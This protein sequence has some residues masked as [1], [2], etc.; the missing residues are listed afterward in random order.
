MQ[1][2]SNES[3]SLI[4]D[5]FHRIL[6]L[7]LSIYYHFIL[8]VLRSL[9]GFFPVTS[10]FIQSSHMLLS[11]LEL[12]FLDLNIALLIEH[13]HLYQTSAVCNKHFYNL[14]YSTLLHFIL[15]ETI[16]LCRFCSQNNICDLQDI[17]L[18]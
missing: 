8:L 13:L 17:F 5:F 2:P 4:R 10:V 11:F 14:L 6:R 7:N 18:S 15:C 12:Y 3:K 16:F 9:I 1:S